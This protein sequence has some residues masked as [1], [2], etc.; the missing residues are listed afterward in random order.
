MI[1]IL[2]NALGGAGDCTNSWK[3]VS[4]FFAPT[5]YESQ[6][7]QVVWMIVNDFSFLLFSSGLKKSQE[8]V[9]IQKLY[10]KEV[11]K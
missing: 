9:R 8:M 10:G 11:W 2:T 7:K 3:S 6:A 1:H 4:S 5:C